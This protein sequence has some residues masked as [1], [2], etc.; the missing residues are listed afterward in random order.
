M[1][2]EILAAVIGG[3]L[4]RRWGDRYLRRRGRGLAREGKV[5]CALQLLS[6]SQPFMGSQ[7]VSGVATLSPGAISVYRITLAVERIEPWSG[8][9]SSGGTSR[10]PAGFRLVEVHTPRSVVEWAVPAEQ[11]D[12]AVSQVLVDRTAGDAG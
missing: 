10:P 1:I 5:D 7:W 4:G 12:W 3:S 2:D 8:R 6:G 11:L 9:T